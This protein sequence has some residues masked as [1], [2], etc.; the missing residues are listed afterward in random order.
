M[1]NYLNCEDLILQKINIVN[2]TN[3]NQDGLDLDGCYRVIVRDCS[4]MF[5]MTVCALKV[6]VYGRLK[7]S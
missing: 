3:W 1:Q 4:L 2:H 6:P 5:M 7:I